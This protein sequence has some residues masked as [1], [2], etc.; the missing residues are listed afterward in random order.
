MHLFIVPIAKKTCFCEVL[1]RF[2][3]AKEF[4]GSYLVL[5]KDGVDVVSFRSEIEIMPDVKSFYTE[6]EYIYLF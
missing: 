2:L 1:S 5:K 4:S 3:D 6:E